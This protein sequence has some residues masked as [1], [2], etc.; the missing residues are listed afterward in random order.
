M[1]DLRQK[2]YAE[3]LAL[4]DIAMMSCSSSLNEM[5]L[6]KKLDNYRDMLFPWDIKKDPLMWINENL[7]DAALKQM[8]FTISNA[9]S[10]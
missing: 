3:T 4:F 8:G 1:S 2:S 6:Q 5:S 7:D 10:T 9:E